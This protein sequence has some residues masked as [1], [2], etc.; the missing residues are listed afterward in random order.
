MTYKS[1]A[2]QIRTKEIL[3][4]KL[5]RELNAEIEA[6]KAECTHKVVVTLHS[7]YGGSY[8]WDND[9]W[10]PETR[11]CLVCGK[12]ESVN[13]KP[14]EGDFK[15]L[16]NPIKRMEISKGFYETPLGHPLLVTPLKDTLDFIAK[17]GY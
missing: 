13:K 5:T 12:I 3:K 2:K 14:V 7:Y 4:Q 11:M 16:H 15:I 17:N 9:D 6:L 8:S 1:L 10:H